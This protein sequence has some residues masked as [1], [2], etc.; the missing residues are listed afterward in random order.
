MLIAQIS[1]T[2]IG[3]ADKKAWTAAQAADGL[4]DAVARINGFVPPVDAVLVTGDLVDDGTS[5]EY[6]RLRRILDRL[7][8][9]YF[10]IPGNH[11]A[12][13]AM[14]AAFADHG[15]LPTDGAFLH[16]TVEEFGLRLIGLDTHVPG[17]PHGEICAA[18]RDWLAA[19]LAERPEAPTLIFMHH[20][21]FATGIAAMDRIGCHEADALAALIARHPQVERVTCG[22]VHRTVQTRWAGTAAC[23]APSTAGQ[24]ELTLPGGPDTAYIHEPCGYLLHYWHEAAG[25]ATHLRPIGDYRRVPI[26]V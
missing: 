18:R 26:D 25:L 9:P 5:S 14:R 13:D 21:P 10:V 23:I 16:Y 12:R 2:H 24:I 15:Y 22:H 3:L 6:D 8:P 7:D 11:D 19:R 17:A 20:P 1:D 4:A